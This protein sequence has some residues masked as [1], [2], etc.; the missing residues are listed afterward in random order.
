MRYHQPASIREE[1]NARECICW[2][3]KGGELYLRREKLE[4]TSVQARNGTDVQIIR[5]TWI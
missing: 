4:E 2:D 5:Q 1:G 3:P